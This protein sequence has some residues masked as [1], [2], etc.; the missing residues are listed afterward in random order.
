MLLKNSFH[1][2]LCVMLGPILF[3]LMPIFFMFYV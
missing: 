2:D 1:R 3:M